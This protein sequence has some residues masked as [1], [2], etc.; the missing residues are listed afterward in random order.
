MSDLTTGVNVHFSATFTPLQLTA[1]WLAVFAILYLMFYLGYRLGSRSDYEARQAREN[2]K[3]CLLQLRLMEPLILK[4]RERARR[5][6][7]S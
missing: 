6:L 7:S 1:F 3:L 4:A 2:S 5:K